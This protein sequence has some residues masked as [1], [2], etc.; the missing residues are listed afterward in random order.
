VNGKSVNKLKVVKTDGTQIGADNAVKELKEKGV[1]SFEVLD[2]NLNTK[3]L[4]TRMLGGK[5]YTN[6]VVDTAKK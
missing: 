2:E 3:T 1:Y 4:F 6:K 5:N